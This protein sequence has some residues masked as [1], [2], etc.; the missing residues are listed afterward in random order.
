MSALEDFR[1]DMRLKHDTLNKEL[2]SVTEDQ[3][4]IIAKW[5]QQEMP[6]RNVFYRLVTHELDH[7]VHMVK[8]LKR[9]DVSIN[10]A[11][12]II[13]TLQEARGKLEGLLVSISDENF[14]KAPD[15]EWSPR[16]V[17]QH[18]VDVEENYTRRI[19]QAIRTSS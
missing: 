12:M 9:L 6:V 10:E 11:E 1:A 13:T 4:E 17:L 2:R 7:T 14:D 15:G 16:Q 18:I 5:D 19:D 8:T 3:M